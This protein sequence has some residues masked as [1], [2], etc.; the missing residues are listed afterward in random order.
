MEQCY[1]CTGEEGVLVRPCQNDKCSA[2]VHETCLEK[3][4]QN[5]KKCGNCRENVIIIATGKFELV[6][7]LETFILRTLLTSVYPILLFLLTMGNSLIICNDCSKGFLQG[8]LF[9]YVMSPIVTVMITILYYCSS[10]GDKINALHH[11]Q[12]FK[13]GDKLL[14]TFYII[15][16]YLVSVVLVMAAHGIGYP[17]LK[18]HFEIDEFFTWRTAS[19]GYGI[20]CV[21]GALL[22]LCY[23]IINIIIYCYQ[24]V[25]DD[26][27]QTETKFGVLIDDL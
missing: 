4:C 1:V 9:Y 6:S 13:Q 26:F 3:Q 19:A 12:K 8:Q 18:Q 22:L 14:K 25:K 23:T 10:F 27:Y 24:S 15:L 17:I 21:I 20:Y 7:C 2:R 11:V 16:F 5:D